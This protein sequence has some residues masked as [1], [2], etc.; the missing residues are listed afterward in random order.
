FGSYARGEAKNNSDLDLM[1]EFEGPI[2]LEFVDLA[3]DIENLVG[4]KVDLVSKSAIKPKYLKF[5]KKH[6]IYV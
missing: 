1:V 6:L 3:D 5:V 2:G 4:I